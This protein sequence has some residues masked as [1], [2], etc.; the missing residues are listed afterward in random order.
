MKIPG[1]KNLNFWWLH[2]CLC[3][4]T[5]V[6]KYTLW[7]FLSPCLS[8]GAMTTFLEFSKKSLKCL[9]FVFFLITTY[10]LTFG[11]F[12]LLI[13]NFHEEFLFIGTSFGNSKLPEA[14][15]FVQSENGNFANNVSSSIGETSTGEQSSSSNSVIG[16]T[17]ELIY[18]PDLKNCKAFLNYIEINGYSISG[19]NGRLGNQLGVLAL[20]LAINLQFGIKLVFNPWQR[21]LLS[22][23]IYV[24]EMCKYD[25]ST[26][27]LV[28]PKSKLIY[29]KIVINWSRLF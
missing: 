14:N 17:S 25:G 24:Q 9:I 20:G 27:C 28:L 15:K 12:G 2:V 13:Q 18:R 26:F 11:D 1:E 6:L 5:S 19:C 8:I 22:S 3:Q 10:M 21:N 16:Q 23:A 29:A 7:N 4:L